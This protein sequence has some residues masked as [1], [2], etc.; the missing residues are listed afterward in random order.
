MHFLN[1]E[2]FDKWAYWKCTALT[3]SSSVFSRNS[4]SNLLIWLIGNIT[5]VIFPNSCKSD[6]EKWTLEEHL[7][8]RQSGLPN[9]IVTTTTTNK[10]QH[11]GSVSFKRY[12][13][14][15]QCWNGTNHRTEGPF[16]KGSLH[17]NTTPQQTTMYVII[18]Y[19]FFGV[20]YSIPHSIQK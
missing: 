17:D 14:R 18:W 1:W 12:R 15:K 4:R 5:S 13:N 10:E 16:V 7:E 2:I 3:K 6:E 9:H 20:R 8:E 19:Q 11:N